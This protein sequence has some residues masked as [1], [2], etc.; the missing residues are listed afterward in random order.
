M[1]ARAVV[2]RAQDAR[3]GRVGGGPGEGAD[4]GAAQFERGGGGDAPVVGAHDGVEAAVGGAGGQLDHGQPVRGPGDLDL[5]TGRVRGV[6][7]AEHRG[8]GGVLV[9]D[10][11]Q[12]AAVA[13][14]HRE[15]HGEVAVVAVLHGLCGRGLV[16][17]VEFRGAGQHGIAPADHDVA[18]VALGDGDGV[19]LV[20][21]D[22]GEAGVDRGAAGR[23]GGPERSGRAGTLRG[24]R[25]GQGLRGP[26][27]QRH[28]AR[29]LERPAAADLGGDVAE[30]GVIGGVGHRGG[31]LVSTLVHTG[32]VLAVGDPWSG[33]RKQAADGHSSLPEDIYGSSD[34]VTLGAQNHRTNAPGE[35]P[36]E[37]W[38]QCR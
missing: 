23:A 38:A 22:R 9:V 17:E 11:E 33:D 27:R 37:L 35:R 16:L 6:V 5:L 8:L 21:R 10:G 1:P 7:A 2:Q 36:D 31:A 29:G 4:G 30:V 25:R 34:A 20:G 13:V 19:G 32:H 3:A 15:H 12:V 24:G 26:R 18:G 28:D 14:V